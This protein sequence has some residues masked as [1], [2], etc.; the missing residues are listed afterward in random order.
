MS[1][2]SLFMLN[3]IQWEAITESESLLEDGSG[4]LPKCWVF[5][6][7]CLAFGGLIGTVW[8]LVQQARA[9]PLQT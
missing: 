7:F 3:L 6:A 9:P 5:T 2:I 1:T 8:I 4:A